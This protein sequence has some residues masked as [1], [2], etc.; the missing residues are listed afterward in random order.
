MKYLPL[1]I[2]TTISGL[3]LPLHADEAMQKGSPAMEKEGAMNESMEAGDGTR[4]MGEKFDDTA[5]TTKIKSKLIATPDTPGL[6]VNVTTN[7]GIVTLEGT[8][9]SQDEKANVEKIA[10]ETNGVHE[11]MNKL[12]VSSDTQ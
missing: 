5:I 8:V 2:A 1:I 7:G 12:V 3:A 6:K 4:S 10:K 9:A 11:V